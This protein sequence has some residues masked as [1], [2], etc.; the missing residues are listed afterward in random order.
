MLLSEVTGARVS[1]EGLK[2]LEINI[3]RTGK[4]E[5]DIR[6]VFEEA[7]GVVHCHESGG[8]GGDDNMLVVA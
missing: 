3:E 5:L 7:F 8:G 1:W 6:G 4:A 2:L